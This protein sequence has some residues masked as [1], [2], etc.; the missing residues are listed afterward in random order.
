MEVK[1]KHVL[2]AYGEG[3][4][5]GFRKEDSMYVVQLPSNLTLY[6]MSLQIVNDL[7]LENNICKRQSREKPREAALLQDSNGKPLFPMLYKL[8]IE[9][10]E[11]LD[12]SAK[13]LQRKEKQVSKSVTDAFQ[14]S[15]MNVSSA[16]QKSQMNIQTVIDRYREGDVVQTSYGKATVVK[17]RNDGT[18]MLKLSFGLLYTKET[19]KRIPRGNKV[20]A[21]TALE[22]N[23]KCEAWEED[24]RQQLETEC[25]RLNIPFTDETLQ[26][27]VVCLRTSKPDNDTQQQGRFY[28]LNKLRQSGADLVKRKRNDTPCLL[29]GSMTCPQHSSASFRKE[30]IVVCNNCVESLQFDFSSAALPDDL[31][32]YSRHLV[33]LYSRALQLLQFCSQFMLESADALE[34]TTRQH[35][36]IGVGGSSAG[37]VSGV[38]GVAAACTILSPAGPPLLIASLVF[39]G[40]AT[41]VQTGSE[42]YKYY[43][44]P[45]QLANRIF[46]LQ[47]IV[48]MIL[49]RTR[50]M[51][52]STLVPYLDQTVLNIA[53]PVPVDTFPAANDTSTQVLAAK[54]GT[55]LGSTVA[56]SAA[57]S[58]VMQETAV[59]S[60]VVQETAAA[61]RFATRATTAAARTARFARF[62]GGALSAA[63]LVLEARELHKTVEHIKLGSPCEKAV[64]VRNIYFNLSKLQSARSVQR[65]WKSY[66]KVRSKELFQ[67]AMMSSMVLPEDTQRNEVGDDLWLAEEIVSSLE[68]HASDDGSVASSTSTISKSRLNFSSKKSL[69][70]RVQRYKELEMQRAA[71][72]LIV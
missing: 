70:E 60:L 68:A 67:Q 37:I 4:L 36:E 29:C 25:A 9:S 17:L 72:S 71:D 11:F 64:A 48:N 35:N 20:K 18:Y 66:V 50:S 63:T 56:T 32:R 47:G 16:I 44:E 15:Q 46:T 49:E 7:D 30:G 39:G 34:Q 27:C 55:R 28:R 43:S 6:T 24:R 23:T 14:Q 12:L 26:T 45:N 57:A 2:T 52:D 53:S 31:E 51:R 13:V 54:A 10:R 41:V 38:L 22:M 42:A 5:I 1:R 62:A 40:S 33:D 19:P 59:A 65:M 21:M 8:R 3:E 61:G 69:L 58:L